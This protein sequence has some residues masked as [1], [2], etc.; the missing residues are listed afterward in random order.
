[1]CSISDSLVTM[2]MNGACI[3]M[4]NSSWSFLLFIKKQTAKRLYNIVLASKIITETFNAQY[5]DLVTVA[6]ETTK[7]ES[8]VPG[9]LP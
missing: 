6:M 4:Y 5:K 7:L 2:E 1:M 3:Y 8:K 9:S